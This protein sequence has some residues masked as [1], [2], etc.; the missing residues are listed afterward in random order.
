MY[1]TMA[2]TPFTAFMA[3][4]DAEAR[5]LLGVPAVFG[6]GPLPY[7]EALVICT[8]AMEQMLYVHG[9]AEYQVKL[10]ATVR[11]DALGS[12]RVLQGDRIIVGGETYTAVGISTTVADPLLTL[13]LAKHL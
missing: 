1:T 13:Q 4:G 9:G 8:P 11:K 2:G 10:L 7:A 6:H 12:E 3:A 5:R